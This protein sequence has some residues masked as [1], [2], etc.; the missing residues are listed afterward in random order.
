[1]KIAK[2]AESRAVIV[3]EREAEPAQDSLRFAF[4]RKGFEREVL[5]VLVDG[6]NEGT[7]GQDD[8]INAR[9]VDGQFIGH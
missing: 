2:N 4:L 8:A 9:H 6:Y 7:E 5:R 3:D 1:V